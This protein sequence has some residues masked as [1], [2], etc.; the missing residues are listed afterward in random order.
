MMSVPRGTGSDQKTT[1]AFVSIRGLPEKESTR[2]KM[3]KKGVK[4]S[5]DSY[6]H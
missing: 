2:R 4:L 3:K 1:K 5:E 6:E